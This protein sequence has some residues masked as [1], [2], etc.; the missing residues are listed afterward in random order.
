MSGAM[1][2]LVVQIATL[3][4]VRYWTIVLVMV[5]ALKRTSANVTRGI[6]GKIAQMCRVK[7][8]IIVQVRWNVV[9]F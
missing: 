1:L 6:V 4:R 3:P 2:V 9:Y 8:S 5:Y 7:V